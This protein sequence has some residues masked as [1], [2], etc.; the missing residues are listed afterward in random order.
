MKTTIQEEIERQEM[1]KHIAIS[2]FD[3]R[4]VDRIDEIISVLESLLSKEE[5]QMK[6]AFEAGQKNYEFVPWFT[7]QFKNE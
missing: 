6:E 2:A 3:D 7:Q 4:K 5:E 1:N